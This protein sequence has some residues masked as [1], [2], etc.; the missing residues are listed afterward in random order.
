MEHSPLD[1]QPIL[2]TNELNF[3]SLPSNHGSVL[4]MLAQSSDDDVDRHRRLGRMM[5]KLS[6]EIRL[7]F[8]AF[9]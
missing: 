2:S 3:L 7:A 6:G 4:T 8:L 1:S 5:R 9:D